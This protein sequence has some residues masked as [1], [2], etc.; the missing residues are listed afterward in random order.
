MPVPTEH[1]LKFVLV[2]DSSVGKSNLVLRFTRG[3]FRK[4]SG[5]TMGMEF[6]TK[7]LTFSEGCT[8]KAQI[9][10]T[11]GQE[12]F[13]SL[14]QAYFRG[15]VGAMIVYDV[16]NRESFSHIGDWLRQVRESSHKNIAISLVGN[17]VDLGKRQVSL[18]EG[19]SFAQENGL[20]FVETSA[21]AASNVETAF[22]RL[23]MSVA[24][25]LPT[26]EA[27]DSKPKRVCTAA[28]KEADAGSSSQEGIGAETPP[29]GWVRVTSKIREGGI[30]Y[31]NI[32]T[33]E[34]VER[35]PQGSAY[36]F[37]TI[38]RKALTG[39][40]DTLGIGLEEPDSAGPSMTCGNMS[41]A[42]C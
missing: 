33:G 28:G 12:R 6:A 39:S 22:R 32:W 25:L 26:P 38:Q 14:T 29:E 34:R 4:E 3:H 13:H 36:E 19:V 35:C 41:C 2:G 21:A 8:V 18:A 31:E 5:Q 9:W 17:K 40:V 1:V 37:N 11:A 16:C 27:R 20:D 24:R 30:S 10:D 42:I 23:I 15:A 7:D